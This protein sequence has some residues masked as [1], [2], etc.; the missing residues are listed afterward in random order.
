MLIVELVTPWSVAPVACPLPQGEG[1]VP[2]VVD[3]VDD[4]APEAPGAMSSP[5]DAS[6]A[7]SATTPTVLILAILF[8]TKPPSG[9]PTLAG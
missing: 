1:R 3:E 5:A 9:G 8:M 4:A 2:N 7:R 6:V